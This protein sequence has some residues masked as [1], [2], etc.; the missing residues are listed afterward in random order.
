MVD[1]PTLESHQLPE[2]FHGAKFGIF[3]HWG[4]SLTPAFA[5]PNKKGMGEIDLGN[6]ESVAWM[7]KH[8]PYAEWYGARLG[9]AAST[10]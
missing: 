6:A 7:F 10:K 8:T 1:Q 5:P 3:V 9:S 2:W 4:V